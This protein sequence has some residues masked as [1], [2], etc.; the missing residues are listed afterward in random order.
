MRVVRYYAK[1]DALKP[2]L[3][4]LLNNPF[5]RQSYLAAYQD[6]SRVVGQYLTTRYEPLMWE[7]K[8]YYD[9]LELS[10]Q[11]S[12]KVWFCWLQG[13]SEAPTIVRVCYNS[14]LKNLPDR[15]VVVID[16]TNWKE[17]VELPDYIAQK[18]EKKVIPPAHFADILRLQ[19]LIRYGGTWSDATVLCTGIMPQNEKDSLSF[20]NADLFLFQYTRPNSKDWEG[21]SNWF[22]SSCTNNEV[23]LVLRDMIFA[24]WKDYDC[25][26]DYYIFH[27]FFS[28]LRAVYPETISTMPYGYSRRSIALGYHLGDEFEE[29]RW[30][31]LISKVCFHKLSYNVKSEVLKRNGNYYHAI[32]D[33]YKQ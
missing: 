15:D 16:S 18:W 24:Y 9:S 13:L 28:M 10:H 8:S 12:N 3:K 31:R 11:K 23:L 2:F 6:A 5:S 26:I 17:Y 25:M 1:M 30:N 7:R 21:V 14:L 4:T 32:V 19:L 27:Q 33:M 20:L 29:E 22:I